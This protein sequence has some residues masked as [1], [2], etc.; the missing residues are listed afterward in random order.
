MSLTLPKSYLLKRITQAFCLLLFIASPA[1]VRAQCPE[2]HVGSTF[3]PGTT[4]YVDIDVR[5][6]GTPIGD[7]IQQAVNDWTNNDTNN[8]ISDIRFQIYCCWYRCWSSH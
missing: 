6:R 4:Y 3:Q 1:L 2:E 5:F 7:Q 8:N